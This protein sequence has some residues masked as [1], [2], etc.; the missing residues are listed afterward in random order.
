MH[1]KQHRNGDVSFW[2]SNDLCVAIKFAGYDTVNYFVRYEKGR[3]VARP[4]TSG[5]FKHW[6]Y[7]KSN[8]LWNTKEYCKVSDFDFLSQVELLRDLY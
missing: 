6:Y 3:W 4:M 7:S 1:M 2:F 8:I 5:V